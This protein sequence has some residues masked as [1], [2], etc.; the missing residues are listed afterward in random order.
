MLIYIFL[1]LILFPAVFIK[2]KGLSCLWCGMIL[3]LVGALSYNAEISEAFSA[4]SVMPHYSL[5]SLSY[6]PA[7]TYLTKFLSMFIPDFRVFYVIFCVFNT[8]GTM[9]YIKKYCYYPAPSAIVLV[10]TGYWFVALCQ[11][12][13]YAGIML[14]AFAFRYAAEKR[15]TRFAVFALFGACFF[16]PIML[17]IPFFPIMLTK[18]RIVHIILAAI[19]SAAVLIFD[20]GSFLD[21]LG[22]D[23]I[24]AMPYYENFLYLTIPVCVLTFI[25]GKIISRRGAYNEAMITVSLISAVLSLGAVSDS[26]FFIL[27]FICFFP[28]GLT[29][30]PEFISV[31]KAVVSLTFKDKKRPVLIACGVVLAALAVM[32][33]GDILLSNAYGGIPYETWVGMEAM[34]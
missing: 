14:G 20:C 15:F 18:N 3:F 29:L 7:F 21:L 5:N 23:K 30:I 19:A 10:I 11:P 1:P 33:Y 28:A 9:L 31:I 12:I 27:A 24:S 2:N 26:R 25:C 16:S 4:I 32:L 22:L 34:Q 8:V 6:P 13:L 17:I